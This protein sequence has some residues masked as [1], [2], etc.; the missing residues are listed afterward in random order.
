MI[1]YNINVTKIPTTTTRLSPRL[2]PD[3][4]GK[5]FG[6]T[7]TIGHINLDGMAKGTSHNFVG[8]KKIPKTILEIRAI[9]IVTYLPVFSARSISSGI[10]QAK[11]INNTIQAKKLFPMDSLKPKNQVNAEIN[12]KKTRFISSNDMEFDRTFEIHSFLL[13]AHTEKSPCRLYFFSEEVLNATIIEIAVGKSKVY[14]QLN[15]FS[16][17]N[18]PPISSNEST[19]GVMGASHKS[20]SVNLCFC[21]KKSAFM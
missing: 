2:L 17:K 15:E 19:M 6:I 5:P 4:I 3:C 16:V 11:V 20:F 18:I 10:C 21:F 7:P 12:R 14:H 13:D 1:K 8:A 9:K